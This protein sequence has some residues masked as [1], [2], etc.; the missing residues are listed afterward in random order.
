MTATSHA[1]E[2]ATGIMDQPVLRSAYQRSVAAYWNNERDP[3]N[4]RLGEVDGFYHH[5]YGIGDYDA[6][7]L[8]APADIRDQAIINE[9]HRLE[10]AQAD[11]LLDQFGDVRPADRL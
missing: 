2:T 8:E 9:M 4:I 10:S 6:S 11:L 1:A 3:V 7:V 5:H